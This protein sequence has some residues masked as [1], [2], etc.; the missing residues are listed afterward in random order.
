MLQRWFKKEFGTQIAK[1]TA[2]KEPV[3]SKV[4]PRNIG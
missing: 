2:D 3:N 1:E 4:L